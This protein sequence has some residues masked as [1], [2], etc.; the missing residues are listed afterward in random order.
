MKKRIAACIY[1]L[2]MMINLCAF[3]VR[4]DQTLTV[5]T[6][7]S[8]P[9]ANIM[10]SGS[11]PNAKG[12]I[13][14]IIE[15]SNNKLVNIGYA[16]ARNYTYS[17]T[18]GLGQ[19]LDSEYT[20][21][22]ST[23][24]N[25][26][27]VSTFLYS[28]GFIVNAIY[29][30]D[31]ILQITGSADPN[32]TLSVEISRGTWNDITAVTAD[33]SGNYS[34]QINL[35]DN[36]L[37]G[38]YSVLVKDTDE[39]VIAQTEFS[40]DYIEAEAVAGNTGITITGTVSPNKQVSYR[41]QDNLGESVDVGSVTSNAEGGFSFTEELH[42]TYTIILSAVDCKTIQLSATST[43]IGQT[44][45]SVVSGNSYVFAVTAQN[46]ANISDKTFTLTYTAGDI[47]IIDIDAQ[48]Y[49]KTPLSYVQLG[50]TYGNIKVISKEPGRL[51]FKAEGLSVLNSETWSGALQIVEVM[52]LTTGDTELNLSI[53]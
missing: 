15:D 23:S 36:L 44:T 1:V 42:G 33:S 32:A 16:D 43:V 25:Q 6:V 24:G 52:A 53:N 12:T 49:G 51:V 19:P 31:G 10:V 21:I 8:L 38:V 28:E 27:A 14:Y 29:G 4:A 3:S 30:T 7:E 18:C 9:N 22:V 47:E 48:H 41:I 11:F 45:L 50:G 39:E 20:V 34:S 35:P 5:D 46:I 37:R 2:V 26:S 40:Y 13:T 17:F